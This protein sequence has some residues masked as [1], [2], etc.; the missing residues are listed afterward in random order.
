MRVMRPSAIVFA[1]VTVMPFALS[2]AAA[3]KTPKDPI[4]WG[5]TSQAS[6]CVIFAEGHK[7]SGRFY[8]VAVTTKTVGKLIVIET[9]NYTMEQKEILE[10]QEGMDDLM[11]LAQKDHLKFVKIPEK[12]PPDLLDKARAFCKQDQ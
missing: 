11:R 9:Q 1:L 8:G 10:T 3:D 4:V 12:Y 5:F 2:A 7:T 6:G